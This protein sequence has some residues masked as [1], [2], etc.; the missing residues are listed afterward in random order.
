MCYVTGPKD[1]VEIEEVKIEL[2]YTLQFTFIDPVHTGELHRLWY[3]YVYV[4]ILYN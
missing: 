2:H 1:T 3:I 4:C